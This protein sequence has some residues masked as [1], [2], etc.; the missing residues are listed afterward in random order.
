MDA[1]T[2]LEQDDDE[3]VYSTYSNYAHALALA[4][5]SHDAGSGIL[6]GTR[7]RLHEQRGFQ[8]LSRVAGSNDDYLRLLQN[9]WA[10]ELALSFPTLL[11]ANEAL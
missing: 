2:A 9:A 7:D 1:E 6:S 11:N 10:A 5:D 3:K 4:C 8:R